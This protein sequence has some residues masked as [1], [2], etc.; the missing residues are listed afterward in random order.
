MA[1]AFVHPFLV[2]NSIYFIDDRD[3]FY[4]GGSM[5]SRGRGILSILKG[6]SDKLYLPELAQ[7]MI[8][9]G[10]EH[11]HGAFMRDIPSFNEVEG[12]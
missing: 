3:G 9:F 6:R 1:Y 7:A 10:T 4:N 12:N 8:N 5:S 11:R 2:I